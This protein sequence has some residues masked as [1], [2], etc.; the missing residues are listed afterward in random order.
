MTGVFHDQTVTVIPPKKFDTCTWGAATIAVSTSWNAATAAFFM[1]YTQS[2]SPT[3]ATGG[4]VN[5]T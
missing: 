4:S 5:T 2:L 1:P 3:R